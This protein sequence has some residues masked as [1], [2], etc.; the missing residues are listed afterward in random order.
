MRKFLVLLLT[1]S[2]MMTMLTACGN[3]D[4]EDIN[5]GDDVQQGGKRIMMIIA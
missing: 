5:Y 4:T 1:L 2:M 3:D